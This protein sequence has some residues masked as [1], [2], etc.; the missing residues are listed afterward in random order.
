M[1]Y[2]NS[3]IASVC[4]IAL[5][6]FSF[7]PYLQAQEASGRNLAAEKASF[8]Q[9]VLA[10][11][12]LGLSLESINNVLIPEA[13]ALSRKLKGAGDSDA[14]F[15]DNKIIAPVS[16][17]TQAIN[18]LNECDMGETARGL[19]AN[20]VQGIQTEGCKVEDIKLSRGLTELVENLE[21]VS[22]HISKGEEDRL[23]AEFYRDV[24]NQT[25]ENTISMYYNVASKFS[26][27][28]PSS[29]QTAINRIY[30]LRGMRAPQSIL[31]DENVNS[32]LKQLAEDQPATE[33]ERTQ[34]RLD[35]FSGFKENLVNIYDD[36]RDLTQSRSQMMIQ[37]RFLDGSWSRPVEPRNDDLFRRP[38]GSTLSLFNL[39]NSGIF[40][41]YRHSGGFDKSQLSLEPGNL[42]IEI[43]EMGQRL[44]LPRTP[45][46]GSSIPNLLRSRYGVEI[47][48]NGR[49][50]EVVP[51]YV[52]KGVTPR[53]AV[54]SELDLA[55]PGQGEIL[56]D[57]YIQRLDQEFAVLP[58]EGNE[59]EERPRILIPQNQIVDINLSALET[60]PVIDVE[61]RESSFSRGNSQASRRL[62]FSLERNQG[63]ARNNFLSWQGNNQVDFAV[64]NGLSDADNLTD[65]T[66]SATMRDFFS[67]SLNLLEKI[68]NEMAGQDPRQGLKD[69]M[70]QNPGV[71]S[72]VLVNNPKYAG[73]AC[74][75]SAEILEDQETT[76]RADNFWAIAGL[77]V[78]VG[79]ILLTG[80]LA[81]A[82]AG[83]AY[84]L[85]I[86]AGVGIAFGV[87]ETVHNV[88]RGNQLENE[89]ENVELYFQ[90]QG[91]GD[92][93]QIKELRERASE[94]F[95]TAIITGALTPLEAFAFF[96]GIKSLRGAA[97][98]KKLEKAA[99]NGGDAVALAR[100]FSRTRYADDI[101]SIIGRSDRKNLKA[102]QKVLGGGSLTARQRTQI[103]LAHRVGAG[104]IGADGINLA[105]RG[106]YTAA[107]I[108]DKARILSDFTPAQRR[109]LME[110]GIVGLDPGDVQNI[111]RV[112]VSFSRP[113]ENFRYQ[114]QSIGDD[115]VVRIV[116]ESP[117]GKIFPI[118]KT[119][120]EYSDF[121]RPA[122]NRRG[123]RVFPTISANTTGA[124]DFAAFRNAYN[125]GALTGDNAFVSLLSDGQ[126]VAG[127]VISRGDDGSLAIRH[128]TYDETGALLGTRVS[129]VSGDNLNL[130]KRSRTALQA[131]DNLRATQQ[132]SL[133]QRNFPAV[134]ANTP[135]A[136]ETEAF[137]SAYN[138]GV[139]NGNDRFISLRVGNQR[140][141]GEILNRADNG[142]L[143]IRR[144]VY[145]RSNE[146][147]GTENIVIGGSNLDDIRRSS[148]ALG[149][150]DL[151]RS[152]GQ[153]NA[154]NA[155][156]AGADLVTNLNRSRRAGKIDV[157]GARRLLDSLGLP[158][159]KQFVSESGENVILHQAFKDNEGRV[160]VVAEITKDGKTT[161]RTMYRSNSQTV[162][163]VLPARNEIGE[164]ENYRIPGYDKAGGESLLTVSSSYQREISTIATDSLKVADPKILDGIL[165]VIRSE[166]EY[167][168]YM[169]SSD[170]IRRPTGSVETPLLREVDRPLS[171]GMGR[172]FAK[173]ED[174]AIRD[175]QLRPDYSQAVSQYRFNSPVYGDVQASVYRSAN[176]NIEYT[177]MRDS[178]NRVWFGDIAN[179]SN[180]NTAGLRNAGISEDLTQPLWEY[181]FTDLA[182][183]LVSQIPDSA[184]YAGQSHPTHTNYSEMWKYIKEMPEIKR[185]YQQN[186]IPIP[187]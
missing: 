77:V 48:R 164:F 23:I 78:F 2:L 127:E 25:R 29:S 5:L 28:M 55:Y 14:D 108:A 178:Q 22:G 116:A 140:V 128:F 107:Q 144:L 106:N 11:R 20:F 54:A 41:P 154:V 186:N 101:A 49:R 184:R 141:Q 109:V 148:S 7:V 171:D 120:S 161:Y 9:G 97:A 160:F 147:V 26:E 50:G 138:S 24:L 170:Y 39:R 76:Q 131:K 152:L 52:Y 121:L 74:K 6:Q 181:H 100:E 56:A 124:D 44:T 113:G 114:V 145:N 27:R 182:G 166:D 94:H 31:N 66:L 168:A 12:Q 89:A 173:P 10:A 176:G 67:N 38:R 153:V 149:S 180:G 36:R 90:T 63:E 91:V 163:R 43:Q 64:R 53:D 46:T 133:V 69:A 88:R 165:P 86:S 143:T 159:V 73:I 34:N 157:E 112:G 122:T 179:I 98:L 183:K 17:A 16:A 95:T 42:T 172:S 99:R 35:L 75:L 129:N 59:E 84:G 118:Q 177:L 58:E 130:V 104:Q 162:F 4:S 33:Q 57:A 37:E 1:R 40:N 32:V 87:G 169:N 139:I 156:E 81:L 115:G 125:E 18:T 92:P 111:P 132:L 119:L 135:G 3:F 82:G 123:T 68:E 158:P 80:G 134:P 151:L 185:W 174:L 146:V 79:A 13:Q 93:E 30:G 137:R 62:Q 72:Q 21:A 187:D 110:R 136:G 8:G 96:K 102:A 126:R 71:V 65:K 15:I 85:L 103:H 19:N 150:K 47:Q 155:V 61:G 167:R 175:P 45:Q 51:S 70:T 142:D 117:S 83:A 60:L 105:A